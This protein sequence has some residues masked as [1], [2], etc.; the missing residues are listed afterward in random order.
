MSDKGKEYEKWHREWADEDQDHT[1]RL[2][3][4]LDAG[5]D[6]TPLLSAQALRRMRRE[7]TG[8]PWWVRD[9]NGLRYSYALYPWKALV[10]IGF[11][12]I[13]A[14]V[15]N[16]LVAISVLSRAHVALVGLL[17][18]WIGMGASFV[19]MGWSSTAWR[20][21]EAVAP[22]N[23]HR[24]I[25]AEWGVLSIMV[26]VMAAVMLWIVPAPGIANTA[27]M[28]AWIGPYLLASALMIRISLRWGIGWGLAV[29]GAIWGLQS[30]WGMYGLMDK[31]PHGWQGALWYATVV[32]PGIIRQA[33]W[34]AAVL[35]VVIV[36]V[37]K[38]VHGNRVG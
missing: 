7:I 24:R 37:S 25:L 19:M 13:V 30:V 27:M 28:A 21:I 38:R 34:S 32:G 22:M 36:G 14:F 23:I 18:P 12:M 31:M 15:L 29:N 4:V 16:R 3:Q 2:W 33:Q 9:W 8:P 35:A 11:A 5:R 17:A 6:N 10:T 20:R 1:P 26:L